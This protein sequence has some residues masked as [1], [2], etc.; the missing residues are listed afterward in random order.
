MSDHIS[1]GSASG[2]APG[3]PTPDVTE[4]SSAVAEL[5]QLLLTTEDITAFLDQ[6]AALTVKV[7]PGEVS[8]GIT[9]R[10]DRGAT[11]V[12]SSDSRAGQVDEVQYGHD[13][14]PCLR[15]VA[16][17]QVVLVEDL[18]DDGRWGGYRVPALGHGVRSSLSLPLRADSAVIGALNLYA[19]V[20]R[21]FGPAEQLVARRFADEASRALELAVRMS[22]RSEMSA[23]LRAA[24]ASRA[25]IDQ[26]LGI[27]MGQHRCTADEAFDLLRG[28]SQNRN[29]KLR[30]VAVEIVTAVGGQPPTDRPRFS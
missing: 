29:V 22:E 18:A 8:C 19:G 24:L 27:I 4:A 5:Q 16:T 13:E 26:A 6:L 30:D 9:L 28:I 10:R 23:H 25:V 3:A 21:A 15:S 11:T 1:P 7:L 20:P 14:G 2:S 17:G 12:A